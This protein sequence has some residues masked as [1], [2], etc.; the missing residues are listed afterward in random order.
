MGA[1]VGKNEFPC[2]SSPTQANIH[3]TKRSYETEHTLSLT[4]IHSCLL[5][6]FTGASTLTLDFPAVEMNHIKLK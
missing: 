1:G 2:K 5:I 3:V 4:T 6:M